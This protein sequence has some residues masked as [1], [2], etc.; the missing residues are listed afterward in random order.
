MYVN[1]DQQSIL[2]NIVYTKTHTPSN[3]HTYSPTFIFLMLQLRAR[4]NCSEQVNIYYSFMF[5]LLK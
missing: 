2:F 4:S 3:A 5:R 1:N